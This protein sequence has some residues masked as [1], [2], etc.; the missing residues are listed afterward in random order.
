MDCPDTFHE[1]LG[2]LVPDSYIN[3]G[4]VCMLAMGTTQASFRGGYQSGVH[5][6]GHL[7]T[8]GWVASCGA[9]RQSPTLLCSGAGQTSL[10][11]GWHWPRASLLY[12]GPKRPKTI[13]KPLWT[14]AI[15][16]NL[17]SM[18]IDMP[19][20]R[21][22]PW[23]TQTQGIP[24]AICGRFTHPKPHF[25]LMW[26]PICQFDPPKGSRTIFGI[27]HFWPTPKASI[28]QTNWTPSRNEKQP[29]C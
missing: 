24:W 9:L 18:T 7:H 17:P 16:S 25:G 27:F 23:Q 6:C 2:C 14:R 19:M 4:M 3:S 29:R 11:L 10:P 28:Q 12:F 22:G 20:E 15:G 13:P 8:H 26:A 21:L 5:E 1:F